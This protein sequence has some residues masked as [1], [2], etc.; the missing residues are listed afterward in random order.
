MILHASAVAFGDR[1]V[2]ILGP[3][4]SGK[5]GLALRT[6]ALGAV[7]V[8]D[9]RVQL[10]VDGCGRLHA[11]APQPISGLIEA[12]G[13]GLLRLEPASSACIELAVDLAMAPE[14]RLPHERN[15]AFLNTPVRLICGANVPNIEAVLTILLQKGRISPT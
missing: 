2:L 12:R 9:D 7:L 5:S 8:S 10:N 14:A 3:S 13:I 1:G 4:G 6:I 11:R 15:I